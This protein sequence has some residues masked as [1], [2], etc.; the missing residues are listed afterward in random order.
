MFNHEVPM[1]LVDSHR[2][3]F[4]FFVFVWSSLALSSTGF[5]QL[6][7][8]QSPERYN[9]LQPGSWSLQFQ[10][11]EDFR[12]RAFQGVLVS[13]KYHYSERTALRFGVGLRAFVSDAE[14]EAE[15]VSYDTIQRQSESNQDEESFDFIAQL[16]TYPSP[17]ARV[18]F[19]FGAGPQ[20][21]MARIH[22]DIR[23]QE[24]RDT[25][26]RIAVEHVRDFVWGAGLSGVLGV[27][28][29]PSKNISFLAEYGA[30]ALFE[31][32]E[33]NAKR[34]TNLSPT[35]EVSE[36]KSKA[37]RIEPVSVKFGLSVYF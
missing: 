12:V 24:I 11:T 34:N 33:S 37:F 3:L 26:T 35:F 20:L 23:D 7:P 1:K 22:R 29:F 32:R 18:N 30:S 31:F 16:L 6:E 17:Q 19:F 25:L 14:S 8:P 5:A 15:R 10:I 36:T 9:S 27:E 13:A 4:V 28:W 2:H 21:R